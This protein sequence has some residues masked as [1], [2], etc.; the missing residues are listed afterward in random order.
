MPLTRPSRNA[1]PS[2]RSWPRSSRQRSPSSECKQCSKQTLFFVLILEGL[3]CFNSN[4]P[5]SPIS[6]WVADS[7]LVE[8]RGLG[9]SPAW[10]RALA[11]SAGKG[12]D[13]FNPLPPLPRVAIASNCSPFSCLW[14]CTSS[15]PCWISG[16]TRKKRCTTL[17]LLLMCCAFQVARWCVHPRRCVH[18]NPRGHVSGNYNDKCL[19][20]ECMIPVCVCAMLS[21]LT[22]FR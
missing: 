4:C 14:P 19:W 16:T 21:S 7:S 17:I 15:E 11:E 1:C 9:G 13:S 3:L 2:P 6:I 18:P 12:L 20:C 10:W 22:L 8:G 5:Q